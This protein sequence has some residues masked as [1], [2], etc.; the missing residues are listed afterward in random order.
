[1]TQQHIEDIKEELEKQ[2]EEI[3]DGV[4]DTYVPADSNSFLAWQKAVIKTAELI[5][6]KLEQYADK[7]LDV[8]AEKCLEKANHISNGGGFEPSYNASEREKSKLGELKWIYRDLKAFKSKQTEH[9]T[10]M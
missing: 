4:G 3:W 1:M 5:E 10:D 6:S 8:L 2:V 9:G 7:K